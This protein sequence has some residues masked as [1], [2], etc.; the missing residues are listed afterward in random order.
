MSSKG[1][2]RISSY[3]DYEERAMQGRPGSGV[4]NLW[5]HVVE[6]GEL[7][8]RLLMTDLREV[9]GRIKW[10]LVGL[11]VGGVLALSAGPP[12]IVALSLL[13]Q[14]ALDWPLGGSMALVAGVFLMVG[15]GI[16]Y[17][18]VTTLLTAGEPLRR[19]EEELRNNLSALANAVRNA[20][21]EETRESHH[22]PAGS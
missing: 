10:P 12:L 8:T 11:A 21:G 19:S 5:R 22:P 3:Y 9:K 4:Q 20:S 13:L 1:P 14:T 7:Q 18:G 16:A 2:N 6:L 17:C 15:L